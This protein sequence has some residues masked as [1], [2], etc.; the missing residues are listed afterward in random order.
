MFSALA[1]CSIREKVRREEERVGEGGWRGRMER[2]GGRE[3]DGEGR[4]RGWER[5]RGEMEGRRI[6]GGREGT[7]VKSL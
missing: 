1:F 3:G 6:E 4:E 5:G 7:P 2:E